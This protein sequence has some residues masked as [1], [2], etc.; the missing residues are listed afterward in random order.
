MH[1][2]CT[3]ASKIH[4]FP[5]SFIY[6]NIYVQSVHVLRDKALEISAYPLV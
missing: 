3:T 1:K 6:L 5:H 2:R 4:S